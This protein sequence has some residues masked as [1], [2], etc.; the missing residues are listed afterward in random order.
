M[1]PKVKITKEDII[2]AA[3]ELVRSCGA[4]A[5]NARKIAGILESST[6]PIFS[7]F[8]SIDELRYAVVEVADK[9]YEEYVMR[10]IELKKYPEYKATG[11]AYIRFAK[12]EKELF[13]LLFMRDRSAEV[14]PPFSRDISEMVQNNTGLNEKTA[15]LFHL[16]IW[17]YVHGIAT[18]MA[19]N[20]LELDM[21]L[22]S[23]MLT[24]AYQGLKTRF[25]MKE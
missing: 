12:E 10:E 24:D 8:E 4:Q 19:T 7:N 22:I 6:Q 16:E 15:E 25:D 20:Y 2:S 18:I 13:K 9:L 17:A 1:P 14:I 21:A 3:V 5:I 23:E 11:M